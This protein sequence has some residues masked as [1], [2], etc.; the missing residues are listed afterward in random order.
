MDA[1]GGPSQ[2]PDRSSNFVPTWSPDAFPLSNL[3]YEGY[4]SSQIT[5]NG[6]GQ[7]I[8]P[9][10]QLPG[11]MP[12]VDSTSFTALLNSPFDSFT[13]SL[14]PTAITPM[15]QMPVAQNVI[16]NVGHVQAPQYGTANAYRP[17]TTHVLIRPKPTPNMPQDDD[18]DDEDEDEDDEPVP[19]RKRRLPAYLREIQA[20]AAKRQAERW[21]ASQGLAA[22]PQ[23]ST[24]DL[25]NVNDDVSSPG[26]VDPKEEE[27]CYGMIKTRANCNRVPSPKPGIQSMW[28]AG[29]Q[30]SIK[31]VLRKNI[32]DRSSKI[33]IID[34]TRQVIGFVDASSANALGPLLD[35]NLRVR[36]DARIPPQ[37]IAPGQEPGQPVS[38]SYILDIVLYGPFKYARNVGHFMSRYDLTLQQ[39]YIVQSGIKLFNPHHPDH[40]Q[41][42]K[43]L[44]RANS[45][46]DLGRSGTVTN[47]TPRT[48]EEV[49]SEVMGV[50]DSLTR[51][52]EL[53]TMDPPASITTPLL[54]HQRQGLYFMMTREQPRELQLQEKAMVSFWR[55]KTNVNGHQVFHNVITG[56][57]QATAP[58]DTRGGILADMMGL[59]KT[60]SILSLISS[61]VEEARQ[62]QY[63][64]PEQPSAPETKPTKGDMDASQAPLGLTP[65]VRNTKATLIICPPQYHY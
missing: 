34:Y 31:V 16:Q 32:A 4:N 3:P 27:I 41:S 61:T 36:T 58:S 15:A 59:G 56:E 45:N 53:P 29:Y 17:Q 55:T 35:L 5:D 1:N 7:P 51:N 52:D 9:W 11:D 64:L 13:T 48:V 65:V 20:Q 30:P 47:S 21:A 22:N 28:G 10:Q 57:S 23:N 46:R 25:T 26:P 37:P 38:R 8:L 18:S 43:K 44:P 39:P 24:V 63:L 62:F 19:K 12:G 40:F 49:R 33:P 6:P 42:L 50:F 14:M 54:T 2:P 60:L